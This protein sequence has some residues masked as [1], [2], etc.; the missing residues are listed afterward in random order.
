MGSFT[1]RDPNNIGVAVLGAGRMGQTH[2]RNLGAIPNAH[3]VV[4]ADPVA[5][6]A[7]RGRELARAVRAST[8]PVEAIL[9][10]EVEAVVIVTPTSTHATLIETAL[11]AGKAVWSE[12]PIAQDMAETARI[13]DLW[14]ASGVPVQL[15]FMRRFDPGYER[16][17][18]LID[19][20]ELGRIEQFRALSRD[21]FPPPLEFL[22]TCGGSFLDMSSHDLDLARFLVGEVEEVHAWASV[23]FDERFAKADDWDTSVIMLKFRN[24]ALGVVETSRHSEWGYDIRTEVAGAVGKVVVDGAQ[25]TPATVLRKFGWEGDLYESFPDRF[26]VA[27]RRELEVFFDNLGAGRPVSPGPDDALETLRLALACTMSWREGRPVRLE[28]VT[29]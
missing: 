2:V 29:A 27:Y 13:V 7:E 3:V 12:K 23:L 24:G 5:E 10:P 20:G 16:A 15:G 1:L 19:S 28:E 22:L 14:R 11:R 8:D 6:V 25:K 26:E 9:D 4:V 21:T 17:K 18:Q